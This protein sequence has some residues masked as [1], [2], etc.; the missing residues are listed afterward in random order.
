MKP[1]VANSALVTTGGRWPSEGRGAVWISSGSMWLAGVAV[2]GGPAQHVE[3][4]ADTAM[5]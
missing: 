4:L 5:R 3:H 2:G 1:V